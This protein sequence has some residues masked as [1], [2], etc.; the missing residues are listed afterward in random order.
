MYVCV[1]C[2]LN[3]PS[4]PLFS[5]GIF[6]GDDD[7]DVIHFWRAPKSNPRQNNSQSGSKPS[8]PTDEIPDS[9]VEKELV[10]PTPPVQACPLGFFQYVARSTKVTGSGDLPAIHRYRYGATRLETR[11][12]KSHGTCTT[13]V[14]RPAQDVADMAK[15]LLAHP[16]CVRLVFTIG[17]EQR[18]FCRVLLDDNADSCRSTKGRRAKSFRVCYHC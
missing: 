10:E 4:F 5:I 8:T 3:Y 16:D 18:A 17:T 9:P 1:K 6:L 15:W 14:S 12:I 11:L 7:A 13:T 2:L